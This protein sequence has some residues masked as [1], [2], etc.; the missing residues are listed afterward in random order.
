MDE[1]FLYFEK[2]KEDAFSFLQ[3]LVRAKSANPFTPENSKP[4]VPIERDVAEI[5]V[6]KI[7]ELG[8]KAKMCGVSKERPNV[9]AS[10]GKNHGK[11]LILNTHMD[12]VMP[13][14]H[15]SFDPYAGIIKGD[16]LYGLGSADAKGAIA[17]FVFLLQCLV[18]NDID[19]NGKLVFTFVVDEEPGA[20]SKFGTHYLLEKGLVKGDAAIIGEPGSRKIN[21]GHRGVC[22]FRI[23]TFGQSVHTGTKE[24]ENNEKGENAILNMVKIIEALNKHQRF[25]IKS[26]NTEKLNVLTFPT[27]IKGGNSINEVPDLC[28]AYADL[29]LW[30]TC[31]LEDLERFILSK[32]DEEDIDFKTLCFVPFVK[33][34]ENEEIVK[35]LHKNASEVLREE[36]KI[37]VARPANDGWMFITRGIPAI[38]GFGP[39]GENVHAK[40]EYVDL[41]DLV[42]VTKILFKTVVDFLND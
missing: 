14:P 10:F 11:T 36:I 9:L 17:S 4:D 23:T 30:E 8:V 18:E 28:E 16:K 40:D 42:N 27:I 29:R 2:N 31:D 39:R 34:S 21:L 37:G 19:L 35:M 26:E 13:S 22:R 3:R 7:E 20:C 24:W 41:I 12:T 32:I 5:I 1:H 33:I 15:Y 6:K 38:C 25:R